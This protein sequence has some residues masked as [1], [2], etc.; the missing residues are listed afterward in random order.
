MHP[1]RKR[2][3]TLILTLATGITV[4]TLL[5]LYALSNNID[6]YFTPQQIATMPKQPK[7]KLRLGGFVKQG[8]LRHQ[9]G[10]RTTFI[11]TDSQNSVHVDYEGVLPAL[12]KEGK[13]A[14]VEG[15]MIN[16]THFRART[17]LAKHDENYHPP[18]V[19]S[20]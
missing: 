13:G 1:I 18:E 11:L 8:S 17:V 16:K 5:V 10:L 3:L 14:I 20:P 2:R 15:Y 6:L 12:F 19:K 4:A 9:Q 7:G